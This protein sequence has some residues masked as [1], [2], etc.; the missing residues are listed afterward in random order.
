MIKELFNHA[1]R[2]RT[3]IV[4]VLFGII[5]TP[6]LVFALLGFDWSTIVPPKYMPFV[7]IA[8]VILNVWMRPRPAVLA[9]DPE[10]QVSKLRK[11][12]GEYQGENV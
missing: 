12:V 6:D 11:E 4:N 3:W 2:W 9:H 1:K 7:T 8:V 10:A 5:I